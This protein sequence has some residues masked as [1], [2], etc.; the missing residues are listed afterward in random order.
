MTKSQALAAVTVATVAIL[1]DW[2]RSDLIVFCIPL[3][4]IIVILLLPER[5][6][7][8]G[9]TIFYGDDTELFQRA[10]GRA[11]PIFWPMVVTWALLL[12]AI[13]GHRER[14][15]D[16]EEVYRPM[17]TLARHLFPAVADMP[18]VLVSEGFVDRI[19]ITQAAAAIGFLGGLCVAIAFAVWMWQ[20]MAHHRFAGKL[21]TAPLLLFFLFISAYS[22]PAFFYAGVEDE[23][24][25]GVRRPIWAFSGFE[26]S[27]LSLFLRYWLAIPTAYISILITPIY[28]VRRWHLQ[29]H[30]HS[31]KG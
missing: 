29:R 26:T 31:G 9:R 8:V 30:R 2:P 13:V 3:S 10:G 4:T 7:E 18:R 25:R 6:E 16:V 1:T 19:A 12:L 11:P 17:T 14:W 27:D 5:A 24:A 22:L 23:V 15:F 28:V 20:V 21:A